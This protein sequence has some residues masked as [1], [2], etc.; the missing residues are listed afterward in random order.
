MEAAQADAQRCNQTWKVLAFACPKLGK[1][2]TLDP[3]LLRYLSG[4]SSGYLDDI[5]SLR[6]SLVDLKQRWETIGLPGKCPYQTSQQDSE[7]LEIEL[8]EL[9]SMQRLRMYLSRLLR[10]EMDGWVEADRWEE[11]V[12]VY[13]KEYQDFVKACIDSREEDELES[14]AMRKAERLWPFD[15]R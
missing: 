8:D 2:T 7:S 13:R 11:I 5:V 14:H 1:A 6:S 9:R 15:L 10:C 3:I 12:P 4:I